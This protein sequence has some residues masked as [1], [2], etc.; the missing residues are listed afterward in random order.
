[1]SKKDIRIDKFNKE[2]KW[3]FKKPIYHRG[4]FDNKN[5][6]ENTIEAYTAAI[7]DKS[8]I[9][10]DVRLTSDNQVICLHDNDLKRLFNRER[11]VSDISYKRINKLRND[12]QVPLLKDVLELVDG[13]IELM[14]EIKNLNS[15]LNKILVS[16][17]YE[18]LKDY[19]GKYVIVSFN[20]FILNKY[21]KKDKE[22]FIGR[23][24]SSNINGFF[25][26]LIVEKHLFN[27]IV[28][29]DFISYDVTSFDKER[30]KRYKAKGY[31]I[32]GWTLKN[33]DDVKSLKEYYDNFIIEGLESREM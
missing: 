16:K 31:R 27:F 29:P 24:G 32:T 14:I 13:K 2:C 21:R 5:I 1:M 8:P 10:L 15:K 22:A 28:K 12:L 7:N 33:K 11:L 6:Y 25:N 26:R 3:L 23:I 17:V 19:K 30:L 4:K 9:E 20:P 18:L